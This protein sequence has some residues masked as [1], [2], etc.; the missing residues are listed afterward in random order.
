MGYDDDGKNDEDED[1]EKEPEKAPET[2]SIHVEVPKITT[3]LGKELYFVKLPNFLSVDCKPFDPE[4]YEDEI[5]DEENP[6][7]E[8]RE[9]LKLKVENTIRWRQSFDS[10]GKAF[11]VSNTRMVRWSDGSMSLHLGNEVFNVQQLPLSGD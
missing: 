7:D 3:D 6:D 8:G 10:E 5:E 11:K 2:V 9:R 4:T 1:M